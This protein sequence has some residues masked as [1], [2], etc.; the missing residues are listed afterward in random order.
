MTNNKAASS[1]L[2][3]STRVGYGV[4]DFASNIYFQASLLYLLYFY[5]DVFGISASVA[6]SIFLVARIVDA[7][8]DPIMGFISDRT[9]TR[10]GKFRPWLII[11]SV[12]M[13]IIGVLT[14][15]A[16]DL[17]VSGKVI[18]AYVTYILFGIAYTV[19]NIPYSSLTAALTQDPHERTILST[20]RMVFAMLG[21]VLIAVVLLP[22]VKALGGG[23]MGFTLAMS[24]FGALAVV[25]FTISFAT[26]RENVEAPGHA[27]SLADAVNVLKGNWPLILILVT[28]WAG[29]M[30][31]TIRASA[32]VYYFKYNVGREDLVP[33]YMLSLTLANLI[34]IMATPLISGRLGK[35]KAYILMALLG[36]VPS[37]AL[38][39]I[40]YDA[41]WTIFGLSIASSFCF[42]APAVLGWAM[43]PDTIEYAEWKTGIRAEGVIYAT[44]SF[45]QKLAMALGGAFSG[46]LLAWTGYVANAEQT[47]GT[48]EGIA[49]M[50]AGA[51][52]IVMA[53]GIVAIWYY[54]LDEKTHGDIVE[55]LEARRR[56]LPGEQP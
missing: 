56:A 16:P 40:P 42:G 22:F 31:Y 47:A 6:A 7:F 29:M 52:V 39:F 14:F 26:T 3:F 36:A 17:S 9:R 11:G 49:F 25:L 20:F 33:Y 28:F 8:A 23:A 35:R 51:P 34:G 38:Y 50:M 54:P 4:G 15:S 18:Y 10:W 46:L 2:S 12:P 43:M 24:F 37:T 55:E 5:T 41:V 13:A 44:S 27:P 32:V 30:G 1:P 45:F 19:V 53:I 48:M 21:A